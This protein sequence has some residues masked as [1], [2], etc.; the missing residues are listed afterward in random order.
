MFWQLLCFWRKIH[1]YLS[2][3]FKEQ[4][5]KQVREKIGFHIWYT[6]E[7]IYSVAKKIF[8]FGN[9]RVVNLNFRKN[10]LI[11]FFFCKC[12][13]TIVFVA[14]AVYDFQFSL[15]IAFAL[16]T[17][18]VLKL[19]FRLLDYLSFYQMFCKSLFVSIS[20]FFFATGKYSFEKSVFDYY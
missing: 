5:L 3:Y 10:V 7:S 20:D 13:F 8:D 12:N 14:A 16:C 15:M 6:Y 18:I 1:K 19:F 4:I 17:T 2:I 9:Q 11:F